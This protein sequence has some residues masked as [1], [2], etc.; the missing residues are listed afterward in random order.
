MRERKCKFAKMDD[1]YRELVA[2]DAQFARDASALPSVLSRAHQ[3]QGN[4]FLAISPGGLAF[5]GESEVQSLFW[6]K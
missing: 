6:N 3:R 4:I 5:N 2:T 1:P